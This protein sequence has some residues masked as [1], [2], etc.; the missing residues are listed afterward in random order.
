[1]A[2]FL[3]S[4]LPL[5][6][7]LICVLRWNARQA[8]RPLALASTYLKGLLFFFPGYLVILI[9]RRIFGFSYNGVLFY[10]SLL[11]QDHL[12]PLLTAMTG[13][14]LVQKALAIAPSDERVFLYSFAG[15]SGFLSM[16]NVADALRTLGSWDA[17]TL[18]LLPCLRIA[19][20]LAVALT[21]RRF[22]RWEG[23]DGVKF[24]AVAAAASA[25]LT[26]CGY[27]ACTGRMGWAA[28]LSGAA[29]IGCIVAFAGRFPRAVQE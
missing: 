4:S 16:M 2:L 9:V 23:R 27:L 17:Y 3:I 25:V 24:F 19:G 22:Y 1:M 12:V 26:A 11:Q 14:L 13:F 20:A 21:A 6:F 18:F 29:V 28:A 10:F 15:I 8:P 5:L 7:A